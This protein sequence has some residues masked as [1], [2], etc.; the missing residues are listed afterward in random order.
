MIDFHMLVTRDLNTFET[1]S[2]YLSTCDETLRHV[3]NRCHSVFYGRTK[4]Y[5]ETDSELVSFIDD[6]DYTMLTRQHLEVI[7][8]MNKDALFTNSLF[9][10][11]KAWMPLCNTKVVKYKKLYEEHSM[12]CPHQ[13]IVLR[14][15][16]ALDLLKEVGSLL[17]EKDWCENTTDYVLRNLIS[18]KELWTYYPEITYK[19]VNQNNGLHTSQVAVNQEIRKYFKHFKPS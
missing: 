13:T 8:L 18:A 16:L 6:D 11:Y 9:K 7:K 5:N 1:N 14:R 3:D 10:A 2:V 4:A 12:L 15:T 19:W 17:K